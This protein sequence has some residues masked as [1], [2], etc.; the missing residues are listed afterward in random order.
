MFYV[1]RYMLY[2]FI[3]LYNS[4]NIAMIHSYIY[5]IKINIFIF[6]Y[7]TISLISDI[8]TEILFLQ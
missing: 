3:M 8:G 5:N 4:T 2:D 7:I 6:I 1:L